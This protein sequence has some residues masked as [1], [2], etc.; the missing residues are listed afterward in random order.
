MTD[1]EQALTELLKPHGFTEAC[2]T[3]VVGVKTHQS[4][5]I[6]LDKSKLVYLTGTQARL[7][8]WAKDNTDIIIDLNH[9]NSLQIIENW[10]KT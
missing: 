10:A 1:I 7:I 2:Y 5:Y 9:P 6:H 4:H 8:Y 3:Q